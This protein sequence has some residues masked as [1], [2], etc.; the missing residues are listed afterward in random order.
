MA[1]EEPYE[2]DTVIKQQGI[3]FYFEESIKSYAGIV[4]VEYID[5]DYRKGFRVSYKGNKDDISN[6]GC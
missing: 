3:D 5:N 6:S 4:I 1:L 2:K